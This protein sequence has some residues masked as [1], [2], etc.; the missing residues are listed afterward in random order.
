LLLLGDTDAPADADADAPALA[1]GVAVAA[2]AGASGGIH[3]LPVE[4]PELQAVAVKSPRA[5]A[6]AMIVLARWCGL[7]RARPHSGFSIT[8]MEASR[9]FGFEAR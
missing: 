2:V 1:S 6:T 7:A 3:A 8:C 4:A 9:T 5:T